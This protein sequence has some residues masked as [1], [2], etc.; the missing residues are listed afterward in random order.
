MGNNSSVKQYVSRLQNSDRVECKQSRF[1]VV[2]EENSVVDTH[3]RYINSLTE[4]KRI[5]SNLS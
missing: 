1:V 3:S 2:K 4:L 5:S